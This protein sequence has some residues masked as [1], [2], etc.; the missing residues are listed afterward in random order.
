MIL[1][2]AVHL[3]GF[4]F[5][6]APNRR[7]RYPNLAL[8]LILCRNPDPTSD[9]R[10]RATIFLRRLCSSR[11]PLQCRPVMGLTGT[12]IFDVSHAAVQSDLQAL[13]NP[14]NGSEH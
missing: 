1:A 7:L 11:Y 13:G 5:L 3:K 4:G 6:P 10:A 2:L 8:D 12:G 14:I 9:K